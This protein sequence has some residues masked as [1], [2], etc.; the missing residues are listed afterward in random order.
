MVKNELL[1]TIFLFKYKIM[2]NDLYFQ[3]LKSIS[4]LQEFKKSEKNEVNIF[5]LK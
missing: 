1:F 5:K 2:L 3:F 4:H